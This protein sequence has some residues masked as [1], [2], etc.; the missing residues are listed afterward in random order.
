ME[1]KRSSPSHIRFFEYLVC[2]RGVSNGE[3]SSLK[4]NISSIAEVPNA[5]A[6]NLSLVRST[7]LEGAP[8]PQVG[9]IAFQGQVCSKVLLEPRDSKSLKNEVCH[10]TRRRGHARTL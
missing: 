3:K 1:S 7:M 8:F 6:R 9:Y 10:T 5:K 2:V 4:E